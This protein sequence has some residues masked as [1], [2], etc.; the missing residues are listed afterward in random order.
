MGSHPKSPGELAATNPAAYGVLLAALAAT[1]DMHLAPAMHTVTLYESESVHIPNWW[2]GE[3]LIS[4]IEYTTFALGAAPVGA[5]V[6][7]AA[8]PQTESCYLS[9]DEAK[10]LLGGA[11][12]PA[13]AQRVGSCVTFQNNSLTTM[14]AVE[15]ARTCAGAGC[16][17]EAGS[18]VLAAIGTTV[19][20]GMIDSLAGQLTDMIIGEWLIGRYVGVWYEDDDDE[21][22][23][24]LHGYVRM[25]ML[26]D[27]AGFLLVEGEEVVFDTDH[28]PWIHRRTS[29]GG[30]FVS[31]DGRLHY[32]Y[33]PYRLN[34][35]NGGVSDHEWWIRRIGPEIVGTWSGMND[36]DTFTL[37]IDGSGAVML[38]VSGAKQSGWL[39][40]NQHLDGD[41]SGNYIY[42]ERGFPKINYCGDL[43]MAFPEANE[44][45]NWRY[46]MNDEKTEMY[47]QVPPYGDT[48]WGDWNLEL[49]RQ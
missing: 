15:V 31:V 26:E 36:N 27:S 41:E 33:Q 25:H 21:G 2:D 16:A 24:E 11:G 6:S 46:C 7:Y 12:D 1:Y 35:L 9:V 22:I 18:K 37:E 47:V 23:G 3:G 14:Q 43:L 4:P 45:Q 28:G 19:L 44:A 29:R 10:A 48:Y 39:E 17:G 42:D 49:I 34:G 30:E 5:L 8:G 20:S 38:T 13:V 32:Q 40:Q